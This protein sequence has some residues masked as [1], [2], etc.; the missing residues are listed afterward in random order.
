MH[1]DSVSSR[2]PRRS[3]AARGQCCDAVGWTLAMLPGRSSLRTQC[4]QCVYLN[5]PLTYLAHTGHLDDHALAQFAALAKLLEATC[6][7][8]YL[9]IRRWRMPSS[10]PINTCALPTVPRCIVPAYMSR[11]TLACTRPDAAPSA[12][13]PTRA[14]VHRY[15]IA[16]VPTCICMKT[17]LIL[18]ASLPLVLK[19][20]LKVSILLPCSRLKRDFL[21]FSAAAGRHP[22]TLEIEKG[23][24]I[25]LQWRP[26]DWHHRVL[27]SV[28]C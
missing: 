12:C 7:M 22:L 4:P 25:E 9:E 5:P 1:A 23:A 28:A 6:Q 16:N 20:V 8:E 24:D 3:S 18:G 10:V 13:R 19:P 11:L 14:Y 17:N 21:P 2:I 26:S 27:H 15:A